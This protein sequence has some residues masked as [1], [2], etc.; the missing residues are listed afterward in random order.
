MSFL[1]SVLLVTFISSLWM[2]HILISPPLQPHFKDS[3][4]APH[5]WLSNLSS[6]I[7]WERET[8][9]V[10]ISSDERKHY[11]RFSKEKKTRIYR[12]LC[13]PNKEMIIS[14]KKFNNCINKIESL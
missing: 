6:V 8:L 12:R 7:N 2:A 1:P 3:F 5:I 14:R 10:H 11:Q 13:F 4:S 9:S